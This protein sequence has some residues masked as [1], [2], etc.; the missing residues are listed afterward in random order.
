MQLLAAYLAPTALPIFLALLTANMAMVG[1]IGSNFSS[2][3]MTPFGHVAGTGIYGAGRGD[4]VDIAI[5]KFFGCLGV[6][7]VAVAERPE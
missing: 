5:G 3:A 2:I 7:I 1:F 4:L 6:E